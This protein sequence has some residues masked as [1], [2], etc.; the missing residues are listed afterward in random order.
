MLVG[1][2]R[3]VMLSE[4]AQHCGAGGVHEVIVVEIGRDRLDRGESGLGAL[5]LGDCDGSIECNHG[6]GHEGVEMVVEGDDLGYEL[7]KLSGTGF[8]ER[9][10]EDGSPHHRFCAT[11]QGQQ[12]TLGIELL[13]WW[14]WELTFSRR[15]E[16]R[17]YVDWQERG[18]YR[19]FLKDDAWEHLIHQARKMQN[20]SIAAM[21]EGFNSRFQE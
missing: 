18:G 10:D 6:R 12:W 19:S 2:Q 7:T 4:A 16:M 11:W 1:G 14:T 13:L 9:L 8:A 3:R 17:A 21:V 20:R 15:R 5:D